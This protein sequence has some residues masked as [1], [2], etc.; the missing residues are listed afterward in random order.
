M[1]YNCVQ[2]NK[3]SCFTYSFLFFIVV[4]YFGEVILD[5]S[6]TYI[7]ELIMMNFFN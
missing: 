1:V 3:C 2:K 7:W 6:I 5:H 4:I